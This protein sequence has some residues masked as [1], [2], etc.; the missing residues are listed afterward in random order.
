M[1]RVTS[2][3]ADKE[4]KHT[5]GDNEMDNNNRAIITASHSKFQQAKQYKIFLKVTTN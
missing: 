1:D 5:Y 2:D 3:S 4:N